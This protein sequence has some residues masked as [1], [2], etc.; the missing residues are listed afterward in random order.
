ML[1]NTPLLSTLIQNGTHGFEPPTKS[2]HVNHT[3]FIFIPNCS[4]QTPFSPDRKP[5]VSLLTGINIPL[6]YLKCPADLGWLPQAQRNWNSGCKLPVLYIK[7][8]T[9][10]QLRRQAS[11]THLKNLRP[12]RTDHFTNS[13]L[14]IPKP[15]VALQSSQ[16]AA[17]LLLPEAPLHSL[18]E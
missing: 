15:T 16:N 5:S 7:L 18:A 2:R 1:L 12:S 4:S 6:L 8:L 9:K 10:S 14:S 3:M 13:P 17:P 11:W